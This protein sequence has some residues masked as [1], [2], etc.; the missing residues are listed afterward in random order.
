MRLWPFFLMWFQREKQWKN[1]NAKVNDV[2][3]HDVWDSWPNWSYKRNM[4]STFVESMEHSVVS[5]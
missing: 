4:W 2:H 1:A 3:I 5:L